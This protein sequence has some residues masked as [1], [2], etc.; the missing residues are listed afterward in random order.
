MVIQYT[1]I[2]AFQEHETGAQQNL[3]EGTRPPRH[4]IVLNSNMAFP[5]NLLNYTTRNESNSEMDKVEESK[6]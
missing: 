4:R 1:F 6:I 5:R 2:G 3:S